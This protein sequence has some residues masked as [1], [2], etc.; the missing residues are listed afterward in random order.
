MFK[1][2]L[3]AM[4]RL[5]RRYMKNISGKRMTDLKAQSRSKEGAVLLKDDK[6]F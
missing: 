4:L 2:T 6:T 3:E 1:F 5:A